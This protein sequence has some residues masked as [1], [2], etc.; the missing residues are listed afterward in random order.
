MTDQVQHALAALSDLREKDLSSQGIMILEGRIVIQKAISRG[1]EILLLV[2]SVESGAPW[3][4]EEGLGFP[5]M[6]ME[7]AEICSLVGFKFHHGAVAVAKRPGIMPAAPGLGFPSYLCLWNVT[8]PSNVG[9]LLRSA[10]GLGV[11][12]VL[13]GPGCADPFYRKALRASMGNS[14]S[15]P[16]FSCDAQGI[17]ALGDSGVE[18]A[19]ATLSEISLPLEVFASRRRR[20]RRAAAPLALVLGNEGFGLPAEVTSLCR[21]EV[22][23]PMANDTDSLNVVVAGSILMYGLFRR[24]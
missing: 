13:L 2:Y 7:H 4:S 6:R 11:Q 18:F 5:V 10:A 23:I 1:V 19:A 15:L 3:L 24:R 14:L 21:S 12:A 17:R 9:A 22:V 16:L 20:S 8:D